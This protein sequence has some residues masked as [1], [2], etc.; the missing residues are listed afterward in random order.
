MILKIAGQEVRT[1]ENTLDVDLGLTYIMDELRCQIFSATA[2]S[3]EA[4]VEVTDMDLSAIYPDGVLFTGAI[5]NVM[6]V[7]RLAETWDISALDNTRA[8]DARLVT[9]EYFNTSAS[10]IAMDLMVLYAPAGFSSSGIRMDSP[11]VEHVQF[12]DKRLSECMKWLCD[13]IGWQ[14]YVDARKVVRFFR[15]EDAMKPAPMNLA[16][17]YEGPEPYFGF[18]M[19]VKTESIR[20]RIKVKGGTMLSNAKNYPFRYDGVTRAWI[21]PFQPHELKIY[22]SE[23]QKTVGIE[24]ID[25]P[26]AVDFLLNYQEQRITMGDNFASP[27]EGATITQNMRHKIDVITVVENIAAQAALAAITGET[28]NNAGVREHV[29]EDTSI[30]TLEAAEAL[31]ELELRKW[32]D[33]EISAS[34]QTFVTGWEPGQLISVNQPGRGLVNTYM[35]QKVNMAYRNK[36]W[37]TE[38]QFGGR[39]VSVADFLQALVSKQQTSTAQTAILQKFIYFNDTILISDEWVISERSQGWTCGDEDAICGDVICL[40]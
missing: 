28:G 21:P 8:L 31:G 40:E 3:Y 11:M 20:N 35:V 29:I 4:A 13:Y 16:A 25:S 10:D 19:S 22:V 36:L 24:N 7:N 26:T 27:P 30:T 38:I 18:Q 2:P 34:F 32:S 15:A 1:V 14:W 33:P 23:V 12:S 9:E 5:T 37:V 39:L 17:A 6:E